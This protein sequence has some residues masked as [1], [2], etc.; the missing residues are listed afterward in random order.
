MDNTPIE[1]FKAYKAS[2]E[3]K[4]SL[5]NRGMFEQNRINERFF[6]G[7]QWYGASSAAERPLVRHNII[8]RI[9]DYKMGMLAKD[10]VDISFIA[11]GINNTPTTKKETEKLK[12]EI[13][14]QKRTDL[15]LLSE[16]SK[17]RLISEALSEY[18]KVSSSRLCLEEKLNSLLKKSF[19]TGTGILY[20][21]WQA[22]NEESDGDIQCEVLNCED[23]CFA[24]NTH[25]DI[26]NQPFIIVATK[27]STES[28]RRQAAS[29]GATAAS[30]ESIAEDYNGCGKTTVLTKFFKEKG[31]N[32]VT[33]KALCVTEKCVVRPEFDTGLR[34]Y[35][36]NLFAW[37][38]KDGCAFGES[39]ITH[40]IP[41][42]IA[43][44]RMITASVW[45]AMSM[46]MPI[47]T[48]NGDTVSGDI[49]NDPGQIIKVYGSNEDVAGAVHFVTP[50][51]FSQNFE[52]NIESLINNTI[53][54]SSASGVLYT[55][56]N[57]NNSAAVDAARSAVDISLNSL[58]NRYKNFLCGVALV[59]LDFCISKYAKR[60]ICIEDKNGRWY[61]PFDA[62]SC[63]K[64]KFAAKI[65]MEN[66]KEDKDDSETD[67]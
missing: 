15:A 46:G 40:I 29:Y 23:V 53:E 47:M 35:P 64:L 10:S 30:I 60:D 12:K 3:Y 58:K 52:R 44:N 62:K 54:A 11:E 39:E 36:L 4:A 42:Q 67:I 16:K 26:Q 8:K 32:G 20:T 65:N 48:V 61:F 7:D 13:A 2:M 24:D 31:E 21:F 50:P 38:E 41:N 66:N 25:S 34:L 9:G 33:V 59:W 49:T 1:I 28:V 19:I 18:Y 14:E 55:L 6:C 27:K 57:S 17:T 5:G 63:C 45:A 56:F 51:D 22:D 37:E 43:I